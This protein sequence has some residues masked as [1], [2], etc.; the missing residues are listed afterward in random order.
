[1]AL[2]RLLK[3]IGLNSS[4]RSAGVVFARNERG[5]VAMLCAFA[6]IPMVG[7]IAIGLDYA[8]AQRVKFGLQAAADA[9]VIAAAR[10]GDAEDSEIQAVANRFMEVNGAHGR[11]V[12]ALSVV[13]NKTATGVR[14]SA[15]G[16]VNPR[17][18]QVIGI[19]RVEVGVSAEAE[20]DPG[21]L[22]IA[23]ALDNTGSMRGYMG[24]LKTAAKDLVNT[25]FDATR[26]STKLKIAVV[27]Y[28]GA[29]NIGN[30]GQQMGWMD[31]T[32]D[33][34]W[35]GHAFEWHWV[36]MQSGCTMTPDTG[37]GGGDGGPG[38]GTGG[39]DRSSLDDR[40]RGLASLMHKLLGITPAKASGPTVPTGY[41][42]AMHRDCLF[43]MN[44]A[45]VNH[46]TLFNRIP[47]TAWKGCVEARAAPYDVT[48][49]PP[50]GGNP[51]TLFVPYF[52]PDEP[53]QTNPD[54][55]RFPNHYLPDGTPPAGWSYDWE[56][57]MHRNIWKYSGVNGTIV[58]VG[59]V[60]KGPNQACPDPIQP[61]TNSKAQLI[62]M[63]D[64]LSHWEGSGTI[65]SE[66]LMWGWRVLSRESG[67]FNQA[68]PKGEAN[69]V[70]VL[71]TD[72]QNWAAEQES[73][74]SWTDYTAYGYLQWGRV[75]P[76]THLGYKAHL[77][78]RLRQAC[79]NAKADGVTIYTVTFGNLDAGT[80]ALYDECAS[81]PSFHYSATTA[82]QLV[83]AFREIGI[84]LTQLRLSK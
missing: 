71:M 37:G 82:A 81:Q 76:L 10:L 57:G 84:R 48:I 62:S 42:T 69:K 46:F 16:H 40:S 53:D 15:D 38:G 29:V 47:N 83:A 19:S 31:Q 79:I 64:G 2:Y 49:T 70:I 9:A 4:R 34:R 14:L 35:H 56:G 80:Q 63:I 3:A 7:M 26:S 78:D 12:Q 59:P 77:D 55:S 25:I 22:E 52:W 13:I 11:E 72:G 8:R 61:L 60:T 33:A 36:A 1:M 65:S 54:V 66:G 6:I 44:P 30:G 24:D 51:D 32:A 75:S 41:D 58:E 27:P 17:F 43:L 21:D 20:I 68:K 74:S 23:L 28:V 73:W 45:K 50:S 39:G 67:T 18:L 5:T